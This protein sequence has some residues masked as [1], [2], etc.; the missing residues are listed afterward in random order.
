MSEHIWDNCEMLLLHNRR[1]RFS[2][3]EAAAQLPDKLKCYITKIATA[4][5]A[6]HNSHSLNSIHVS[7]SWWPSVL[8]CLRLV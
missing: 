7:W 2:V 1:R 6:V 3:V 8:C 5:S 4:Q